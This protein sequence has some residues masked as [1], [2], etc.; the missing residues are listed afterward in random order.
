MDMRANIA[1]LGAVLGASGW[2]GLRLSPG[3]YCVIF[4]NQ[5]K[6][7]LFAL[8]LAAWTSAWPPCISLLLL[9]IPRFILYVR[10][11]FKILDRLL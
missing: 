2:R 1:V 6:N 10:F 7:F 4:F 11:V 3:H 8:V 5:R 9:C